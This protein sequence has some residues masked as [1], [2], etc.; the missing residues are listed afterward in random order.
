MKSILF[1]LL[2]VILWTLPISC[3]GSSKDKAD[4]ESITQKADAGDAVD[5][6]AV[7]DDIVDEDVEGAEDKD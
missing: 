5:F 3:T 7:V 6:D 1:K 2:V 4:A